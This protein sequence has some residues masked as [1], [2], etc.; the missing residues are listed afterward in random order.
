MECDGCTLCCKLLDIPWM[1]STSN[2]WCTECKPGIGCKIYN[3]ASTKCKDYKCAFAQMERAGLGFRPDIC[4]VIF[5]RATINIMH[6][7]LDP[8]YD[9]GDKVKQQIQYFVNEGLSVIITSAKWKE[10]RI[11]AAKNMT[12]K[13]VYD[14]MKEKAEGGN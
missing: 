9:L 6:G 14:A 8:D 13:Y 12:A 5:E 11:W 4:H 10:P 1:D 3:T 7:L 2:K